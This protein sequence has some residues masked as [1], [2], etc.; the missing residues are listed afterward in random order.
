MSHLQT[1]CHRAALLNT[2]PRRQMIP[3]AVKDLWHKARQDAE[4][5]LRMGRFRWLCEITS[6]IQKVIIKKIQLG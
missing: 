6:G 1:S 5:I 2:L 4:H 3:E